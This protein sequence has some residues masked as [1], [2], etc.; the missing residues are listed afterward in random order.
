MKSLILVL[1]FRQFSTEAA[2]MAGQVPTSWKCFSKATLYRALVAEGIVREG[3]KMNFDRVI[4]K[5]EEKVGLW[6]SPRA[7]ELVATHSL[8][9]IVI[10][11]RDDFSETSS[12]SGDSHEGN[13]MAPENE[14][15]SETSRDSQETS[16][17]VPVSSAPTSTVTTSTVTTSNSN[18]VLSPFETSAPSSKTTMPGVQGDPSLQR[19]AVPAAAGNGSQFTLD[20]E[21]LEKLVSLIDSRRPAE[22]VPEFRYSM[23]PPM[24][25]EPRIGR[26]DLPPFDSR[27]LG[28]WFTLFE[29]ILKQHDLSQDAYLR[30][31]GLMV[32]GDARRVLIDIPENER[33]YAEAKR[34]ILLDKGQTQMAA[35]A[36]L[37]AITYKIGDSF[38][39]LAR[40]MQETLH[41]WLGKPICEESI[42]MQQA[43]LIPKFLELIPTYISNL[44]RHAEPKTLFEAARRAEVLRQ[45]EIKPIPKKVPNETRVP[46]GKIA[47]PPK[48]KWHMSNK[49]PVTKRPFGPPKDKQKK[50]KAPYDERKS[51][52]TKVPGAKA[53]HVRPKGPCFKCGRMGHFSNDC[54]AAKVNI[55]SVNAVEE[56]PSRFKGV[57]LLQGRRATCRVDTQAAITFVN[58]E[59]AV[60]CPRRGSV[61]VRGFT[62]EVKTFPRRQVSVAVNGAFKCVSAG[63]FP[64]GMLDVDVLLGQDFLEDATNF[65][66]IRDVSNLQWRS[67]ADSV[68]AGAMMPEETSDMSESDATAAK[69][70]SD[71][72]EGGSLK[73]KHG[74]MSS[75]ERWIG[76]VD[77][78]RTGAD[79]DSMEEPPAT[80]P[81]R[82]TVPGTET[83]GDASSH[84]M[85]DVNARGEEAEPAQ[86]ESETSPLPAPEELRERQRQCPSLEASIEMAE[87]GENP[88]TR[89]RLSLNTQGVLVRTTDPDFP[90][91]G[92]EFG[93]GPRTK[94]QT[95]IP[96]C[97]A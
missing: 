33:T 22:H 47:Q 4:R 60:R 92:E 79:G 68:I 14:E 45:G 52:E 40:Q 67:S 66:S 75:P 39:T 17:T 9:P 15:R 76:A 5:L 37:A 42:A 89:T 28:A 12:E 87:R 83:A 77:V 41:A 88:S 86:V 13:R 3:R 71:S 38:D 30:Y 73:R 97:L 78:N 27:D 19:S 72:R 80:G 94:V 82:A 36:K 7:K 95:V 6:G 58:A 63:V 50:R 29:F 90:Q 24:H 57:C 96:K 43:I 61:R 34:R 53:P 35:R 48:S 1:C 20:F 11:A 85:P 69:P 81:I 26:T 25:G 10:T 65:L 8:K 91:A 46:H 62:G 16:V 54:F 49:R 56:T 51:V 84:P 18:P 44:V 55:I 31:L 59:R 70:G 2:V 74:A 93:K 32:D 21:G 64:P 23:V